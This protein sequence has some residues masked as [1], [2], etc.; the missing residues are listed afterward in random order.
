[1]SFLPFQLICDRIEGSQKI[2]F[3]PE[4]AEAGHLSCL[5]VVKR[6][7]LMRRMNF[8]VRWTKINFFVLSMP[9]KNTPFDFRKIVSLNLSGLV[10]CGNFFLHILES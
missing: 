5:Y 4:L 9:E 1:M 3:G 8:F 7:L 2:L 6:I 10:E